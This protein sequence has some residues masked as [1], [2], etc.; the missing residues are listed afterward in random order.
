MRV[1]QSGLWSLVRSNLRQT[2]SR[3]REVEERAVSGMVVNRASDAPA[4]LGQ[5]DRLQGAKLDQAV[6]E[7]NASQAM[8]QLDQ[9]DS[10]LGT[11]HDQL[12]RARELAVQASSD[13]SNAE[14]RG[15]IAQ[16]IESIR[17][18]VLQAANADF[19]GRYLFAGTN[20][21]TPPYDD[22]GTYA[23]STDV[24]SV[25]VGDGVWVQTARD[26]SEVFDGDVD[27]F[28]ALDDFITA[29]EADD[30]TGIAGSL[31]TLDS[32]LD[33]VMSAR[34]D[35]GNDARVAEDAGSLADSLSTEIESRL[36]TLLSADPAETYTQLS[37]LR[38]AYETALQVASSSKGKSLFDL[39]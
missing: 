28:G 31:D 25:R 5:I 20:W 3:M 14:Q 35:V 7:T 13:L 1:T 39:I 24:P 16:E 10:T 15:Y 29:L 11:I 23:G 18:T 30:S 26:G 34:A 2:N 9:L 19:A 4:L 32:A 12:T 33:Q 36:D 38:T 27:I 17:E 22:T 8:A 21:D 6:Y 37:E